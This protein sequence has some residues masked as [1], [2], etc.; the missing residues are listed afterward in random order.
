MSTLALLNLSA[1]LPRPLVGLLQ[2]CLTP[3]DPACLKDTPNSPPL[4]LAMR[5]PCSTPKPE[6]LVAPSLTPPPLAPPHC[7]ELQTPI[8]RLKTQLGIVCDTFLY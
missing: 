2:P 7:Y 5:L 1:T 8:W 3:P 6:P 4:P